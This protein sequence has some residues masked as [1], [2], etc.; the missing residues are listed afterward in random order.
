MVNF[1]LTTW[2]SSDIIRAL[3]TN[4][5]TCTRALFVFFDS[6]CEQNGQL[7]PPQLVA[8]VQFKFV[9]S[10]QLDCSFL[11][12]RNNDTS[13]IVK[14]LGTIIGIPVFL[15]M[16]ALVLVVP[17]LFI[18]TVWNFITGEAYSSFE[19][20]IASVVLLLIS[21]GLSY[22]GYKEF[23]PWFEEQFEKYFKKTL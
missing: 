7:R 20:L 18:F 2:Y 4:L 3:P 11:R 5:N 21:G 15:C 12:M 10:R 13:P 23:V 16:G 22:E 8:L 17:F 9:G 6:N 14:V 19:N 1:S